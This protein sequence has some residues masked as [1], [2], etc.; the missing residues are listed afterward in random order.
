MTCF[1]PENVKEAQECYFWDIALIVS[2]HLMP[3]LAIFSW[4]RTDGLLLLQN[5]CNHFVRWQHQVVYALILGQPASSKGL[6]FLPTSTEDVQQA[7]ALVNCLMIWVKLP[8]FVNGKVKT[9]HKAT[10]PGGFQQLKCQNKLEPLSVAH[11]TFTHIWE[12]IK[13]GVDS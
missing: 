11:H 8:G 10:E 12:H 5:S 7:V 4:Y 1:S 2:G 9:L 13:Y 3:I 6:C